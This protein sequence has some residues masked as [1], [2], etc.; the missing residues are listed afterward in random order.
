MNESAS[1]QTDLLT[2]TESAGGGGSLPRSLSGWLTFAWGIGGVL[3]LFLRAIWRMSGV[4][5]QLDPATLGI[6]HLAFGAIWTAFMA[7]SEGYRAFQLRFSPRVVK[8]ALWLARAGRPGLALLAPIFCMGLVHASRKRLI[9]SWCVLGLIVLLIIGVR[10]LA[11][12]WRGLV[13]AGVVVGLAWGVIA[14]IAFG[15]RALRGRDIPGEL[16]LP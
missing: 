9:V 7:Y 12:P 5:A 10:M 11:Q 15:V 16:D 13:D 6:W 14:I 4:A 3:L 8:R 2:L 1:T